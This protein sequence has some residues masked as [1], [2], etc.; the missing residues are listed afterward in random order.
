M[1]SH[2]SGNNPCY[3]CGKNPKD[4]LCISSLK[5]MTCG[6]VF[7]ARVAKP[8]PEH[9]KITFKLYLLGP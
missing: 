6:D 7:Y 3:Y 1:S 5:H 4:Q 8:E 2:S 9:F